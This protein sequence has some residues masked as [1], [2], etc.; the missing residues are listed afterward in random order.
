MDD[1]SI[2]K[3]VEI[4]LQPKAS[5]QYTPSKHNEEVGTFR[6]AMRK[7]VSSSLFDNVIMS[8]IL[9]N[10]VIMALYDPLDKDP[11]SER[12]NLLFWADVVFNTIYSIEM[13]LKIC[14]N[15]FLTPRGSYLSDGWNR[16]DFVI[17]L[18]G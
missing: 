16:M 14:A 10:S 9:L 11:D 7:I 4:E 8:I 3:P 12:N 5:S 6:C 17:V 13:V 15:G 1:L 2:A 18:T